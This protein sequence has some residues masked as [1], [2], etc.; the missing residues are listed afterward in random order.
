MVQAASKCTIMVQGS[1]SGKCGKNDTDC[2]KN[3]TD[4]L[5]GSVNV[6]PNNSYSHV[7]NENDSHSVNDNRNENDSYS[8]G[9]GVWMGASRGEDSSLV[10]KSRI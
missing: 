8:G 10:Q 1:E 6:G 7:D 5:N 9:R 4:G 3:E 2:G